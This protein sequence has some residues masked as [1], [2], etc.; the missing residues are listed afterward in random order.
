[1]TMMTVCKMFW[2]D[3]SDAND[4]SEDDMVAGGIKQ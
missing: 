1:M 2:N 4:Y 3:T